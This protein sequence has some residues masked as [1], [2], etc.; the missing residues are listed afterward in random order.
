[1]AT[2]KTGTST[3]TVETYAADLK[4]RFADGNN[5]TEHTH[6]PALQNLLETIGLGTMATNEPQRIDCGSPDFVITRN[7]VPLGYVEAKDIGKNLD[8][9]E[10]TDQLKRYFRS[11]DNLIFT[12]YLEFRWYVKGK[13]RTSLSI[14]ELKNRKIVFQADA[15]S[16]L[17]GLINSFLHEQI[18]TVVSSKE[19]ASRL[20]GSAINLRQ[21]ISTTFK[22]ENESGYLHKWIKAF[23]DT[24]ISDLSEDRFADMFAQT[25]VYGFFSAR[26]NHGPSED[27]NREAASRIIPETN[28]FLR[29]LFHEFVG[30]DMPNTISW[31]VD[32]LVECLRRTDVEK[33][34]KDFGAKSGRNDPIFHFYETFLSEYDPNLK[35][36]LGVY[37][38]PAPVINFITRSVDRVIQNEFGRKLGLADEQTLILDPATGTGSFLHKAIEIIEERMRP[39]AGTWPQYVSESLLK[40]IFGFEIMMA[41]HAIAHFKLGKQLKD[42]GYDFTSGR[43]LGVYLTNT[44][45]E[46]ASKSE[47]LFAQFISDEANEAAEIK[48]N[49]QI[50][51]VFGNPPY[52]QYAQNHG[53]WIQKLM[54]DYKVGLKE[55][56]NNSDNDYM[57]FM[58]FAQW[59]IEKTGYGVAAFITP[60]SFLDAITL[61]QMRSSLLNSYNK[62]YILNLHGSAMV[63]S[64]NKDD[65]DKNVFEIRQGVAI[66]VFVKEKD[67]AGECEV[68]YAEIKGSRES[69]Y[70]FL[71]TNDVSTVKWET[72]PIAK[73]RNFFT[74]SALTKVAGYEEFLSVKDIFPTHNSGIQPKRKEMVQ[75]SEEGVRQIV[76]DLNFMET[77]DLRAKYRLPEDNTGWSIAKAK[78]HAE[79]LTKEEFS[80]TRIQYRTFDYRW[81]VVE[82]YSSGVIGR[83]RWDIMRHMRRPN[84]IGMILLRQLSCASFQHAWVTRCPIDENT[85]SRKTREYN[86]L[87]P[88]FLEL[89]EGQLTSEGQRVNLGPRIQ[90]A[91]K[92]GPKLSLTTGIRGDF[93]KTIGPQDIFFYVYGILNSPEYRAKYFNEL[94]ID[95]PRVPIFSDATVIKSVSELGERM[96][97]YHLLEFEM[98]ECESIKF[99][100][101]GTNIVE[102]AEYDENLNGFRINDTQ[103]FSPIT[104][105]EWQYKVGGH[106]VLRAFFDDR[107]GR[108]LTSE[109]IR[110]IR[111]MVVSVRKTIE[112]A[113]QIDS[114]LETSIAYSSIV[115]ATEFDIPAA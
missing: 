76:E 2:K 63:E 3:E 30:L 80:P 59:R 5:A 86:Y 112:L 60:N 73:D 4:K 10:K 83:P 51:A 62:I 43:R 25:L 100:V 55:K 101:R 13:L 89:E 28:P 34:L 32:E 109:E 22:L 66:S 9:E 29:R 45:E 88:L 113:R 27:F 97:K 68:K 102:N 49:R 91:L 103:Y 82:D 111:Q 41:P 57:K 72:L 36:A 99:P 40:R 107:R 20:A 64:A 58:R 39:Q 96:A 11:L 26:A 1:M 94:R 56:K 54:Q 46:A 106:E 16:A 75:F 70:A 98:T 67:N 105:E 61:R 85:I 31:A 108:Q 44:L 8:V 17:A 33:V 84:N 71:D 78:K 65:H 21:L 35:E 50:V 12:N 74:P 6:R 87:F 90:N 18:P 15:Y 79:K 115:S 42:S 81:T 69:K 52:K 19:L 93:K 77:E 7:S 53:K 23:R 24:L 38:T 47:T 37:Y 95:F 48:A 104:H 14:G 110:S 92:S 114:V